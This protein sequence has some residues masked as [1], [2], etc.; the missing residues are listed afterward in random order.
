MKKQT[1]RRLVA[2]VLAAVCCIGMAGQNTLRSPM[3]AEAT[4]IAELE[5]Q[6]AENNR[7]I[8][9]YEAKL[10]QFKADQKAQEAYQEALNEKINVLQENL[11]LMDTEL[12]AIKAS[13]AQLTDDIA[14]MEVTIE[15]Q[16]KDIDKGLKEFKA[17]LRA[18]YV[19]GNDSL[20]SVL[21]G[22]TDFY[23]LLSKY[24]M[25]SCIARHDDELV[26]NLRDE[27][28]AYNNNLVLLE[29]Q[30]EQEKKEQ[31]DMEAKQTE[32]K[33]SM[34]ELQQAYAESEA[35]K[36]RLAKEQELANQ[37]IANLEEQN[38]LANEAED[39]IRNEIAR[40]EEEARRAQEQAQRLA[41]EQAER[42]RQS[43]S[44]TGQTQQQDTPKNYN[45]GSFG[46]PCPGHYYISSGFGSRWGTT[47]KGIDIAQNQGAAVVASRSGT[48]IRSVNTCTHNYGKS[49]N[50][51]GNG[52][53][54]HVIIQHDD[55]TYST[56][57]GHMEKTIVSVGQ[58]VNKGDT[59]GYVGSTGWSTGY[60]LHF[61]VRKNGTAVDPAGYLNY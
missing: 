17:R 4:T 26:N 41:A 45:D 21:V 38:R 8:Q 40:A 35:E 59:I 1:G 5:A 24:E 28:E 20:A 2:A 19:N 49:A 15:Q 12:E 61:E 27:L 22:A 3:T 44:Q 32:M 30:K 23:D 11:Q 33:N 58:Y 7:R 57:Y 29:A 14:D 39:A 31:A 42:D 13:I 6:K 46:W 37:S 51:C 16:E 36:E 9:E 48:V 50:C 43:G 18:M 60:H 53:G 47:H 34:S 56:L 54:N 25:I 10:A 55:G 52:Y